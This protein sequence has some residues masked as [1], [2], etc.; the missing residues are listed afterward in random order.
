MKQ[1]G[2]NYAE[3]ITRLR[4]MEVGERVEPAGR[5]VAVG[6]SGLLLYL[7]T[8]WIAAPLW[9]LYFFAAFAAHAV[10]LATRTS[11]VSLNE[12]IVAALLFTHFQL[13][14]AWLP[15]LMFADQD[16]TLMLVGAA[17]VGAQLLFM[18]R[19]GDTFMPYNVAQLF[20]VSCTGALV[21]ISFIPNFETPLAF[22]GAAL[23]V[24]GVIFYFSQSMRVTRRMRLS[25]EAAADQAHQAQKMAAIGQLAGG[26][27]HDFNNSLTA[28]IGSLEL[29]QLTEDPKDQKADL[30]NALVAAR[31]AASTVKQLMIFARMEKPS[32]SEIELEELFSEFNILTRRLIPE[33]IAIQTD[34]RDPGVSI[35][36]DRTQLL[37]GLVNLVA[38][39]VD[40]MPNGGCLRV[41]SCF[42][43]LDERKVMADG[44]VLGTGQ[45]ARISVSDTG[46]GIPK[47]AL[48]RVLDPFFT[49]KP[50]G[51][52]TGLGLSMVAGMLQEFRGGLSIQSDPNGT[53]VDLLLPVASSRSVGAAAAPT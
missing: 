29:A 42:E 26:V 52:G 21:Y 33:S 51:K 2:F 24:A 53:R 30:Q 44:S 5:L 11:F 38:N 48:P 43:D 16:R 34:I 22:F 1:G 7:Y 14:Y 49:T 41:F 39:S 27:A 12:A 23:A 10:F 40:A 37:S 31:Q 50:A 15:A 35:R 45:Y 19:R 28:I 13:A 8:G 46:L 9:V 3:E 32:I 20:V 17:L 18:I 36:A 25:R 4:Q 47:E 6:V